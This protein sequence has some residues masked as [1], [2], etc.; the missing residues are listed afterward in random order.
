[1]THRRRQSVLGS[2]FALALGAGCGG[3]SASPKADGAA[4]ATAGTTGAA[5]SAG[6]SSGAAGDSGNAGAGTA[7][8]AGA[9]VAGTTGAAGASG[10]ATG[11]AGHGGATGAAGAIGTG[12]ATGA[13]CPSTFPKP[14]AGATTIDVM[15]PATLAGALATA[16]A[17]DRI[18]L[19]AGTYA[20]ETVSKRS[21][22]SFVF[23]EAAAGE[24][25]TI[26][27]ASF[28][29]S[30][31]LA[32]RDLVFTATVGLDGSSNFAFHGVT[33]DGG[34]T[35]DAALHLHGQGAA[36]ATH[37][38]LVEDSIIKGGGRT[39]FI[40]GVFAPSVG[41]NHHLTFVRDDITCGTHNCFQVSGGRDLV[42][43]GNRINGTTTSGVLTAGATRVSVTRNRFV[44]MPGKSGSAAQIASPGMEWD[45]YAGVENM[46]ST[47]VVFANNV[48]TGWGA[49]VTLDAARDVAIVYNTVAD[50]K[51]VAFDHRVPHDQKGNVILDGNSNIRIWNNVMP[52]I[53]AG[54]QA[55]AF[56]SNSVIWKG[57]ATGGTAIVTTAPMFDAASMDFALAAGSVGLDAALVNA[58]T[59][60]VDITNRARGAKPD[61]GA[62]ELG[63]AGAPAC[64]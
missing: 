29:S 9:G 54:D 7:G 32:I 57:G 22:A 45:N 62:T 35:E 4:G 27:G 1:M 19:H 53:A 5:G 38:V 51:G 30:D 56:L 41:W 3:G 2:F 13:T 16:K 48:V 15:A 11:A 40:L 25:V 42:I 64:P 28:T 6:S 12:G 47:A 55:P 44:G 52:S 8:V 63:A 36:G 50:G 58:E 39:I 49:A 20:K 46:T 33:F 37:D 21:F 17:G 43:D 34:A 61:V 24:K 60:L 14:A 59:P 26:A 31:H 10:G 18:V 23:I